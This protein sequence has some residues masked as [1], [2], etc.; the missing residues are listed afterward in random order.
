MLSG[1]LEQTAFAD[2][3]QRISEQ[4]PGQACSEILF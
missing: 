1:A 3:P 2:F 4:L